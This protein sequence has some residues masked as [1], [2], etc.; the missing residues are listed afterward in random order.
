MCDLIIIG[1]AV[2]EVSMYAVGYSILE[3]DCSSRIEIDAT[4]DLEFPVN[5]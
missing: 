2:N 3:V 5:H 1:A 4:V